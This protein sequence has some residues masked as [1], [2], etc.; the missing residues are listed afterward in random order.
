MRDDSR[1]IAYILH[2]VIFSGE[3]YLSS[4][5]TV[6]GFEFEWS[7]ERFFFIIL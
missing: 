5:K 2:F 7:N 3:K 6:G 4:V 1:Q